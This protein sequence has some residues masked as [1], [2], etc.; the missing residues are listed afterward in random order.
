M[1]QPPQMKLLGSFRGPIKVALNKLLELERN[2][3]LI[4]ATESTELYGRMPYL[5]SMRYEF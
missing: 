2:T 4:V 3:C 5:K 1:Q